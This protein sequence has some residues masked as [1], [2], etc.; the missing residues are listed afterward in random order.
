MYEKKPIKFDSPDLS[1]LQAVIINKNTTIFIANDANPEQAKI[2]YLSR[3]N[4]K[5]I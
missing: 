4:R 2:R 1:K 3:F 5:V